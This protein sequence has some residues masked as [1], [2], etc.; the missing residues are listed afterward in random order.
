M[1]SSVIIENTGSPWFCSLIINVLSITAL[2]SSLELLK[3][4]ALNTVEELKLNELLNI[5][6]TDVGKSPFVVYLIVFWLE[7]KLTLTE[8]VYHPD[9]A[10]ITGLAA[11]PS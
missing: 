6:S 5:G 10:S 7:F 4:L 8:L 9:N 3:A 11:T 1:S 2:G